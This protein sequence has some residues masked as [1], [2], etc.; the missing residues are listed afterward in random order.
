MIIFNL[1]HLIGFQE[2][3]K[4]QNIVKILKLQVA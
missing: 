2:T 4:E 3:E 1:A